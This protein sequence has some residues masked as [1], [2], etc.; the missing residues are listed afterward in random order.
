MILDKYIYHI[1]KLLIVNLLSYLGNLGDRFD[2]GVLFSKLNGYYNFKDKSSYSSIFK[3]IEKLE[4]SRAQK[5]YF[6][7]D[8]MKKLIKSFGDVNIFIKITKASEFI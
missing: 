4:T 7:I 1:E 8:K 5:T 3:K 6:I 2:Y